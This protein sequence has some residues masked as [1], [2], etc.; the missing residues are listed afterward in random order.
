MTDSSGV[1]LELDGLSAFITGYNKATEA[2]AGF[3]RATESAAKGMN[4][5]NTAAQQLKIDRIAQQIENGNKTLAVYEQ[6]LDALRKKHGDGAQQVVIMENRIAAL[7][8]RLTLSQQALSLETDKL[9]ALEAG[10]DEAAGTTNRLTIELAQVDSAADQ[11]S[12][13]LEKISEIAI[14]AKRKL[15]ELAVEGVQRLGSD[16]LN[17][18]INVVTMAGDFEATMGRFSAVAGPLDDAGL[19]IEQFRDKFLELGKDTQFSAQQAGEA[20]I[21][22]AKGGVSITEVMGGATDA[23][24]ALA[25][26]AE[27]DLTQAATIVAKQLAVWGDEAGGAANIADQFSQAAAASTVNADDLALG[28]A[29]VGGVA[30]AAGLSFEETVATIGLISS[31]FSS[32]SDAGTSFKEFIARLQPDSKPA[33]EAMAELGLLTE[34]GTSAFYDAQGAFVGQ[35]EATR[36]LHEAT[37]DLS[38]AEQ[39]RL[40][41][42]AFGSDAQRTAI[43]L[44]KAGA[45]GYDK[46][47]EAMNRQGDAS[48]QAARKNVGFNFAL[49]QLRG[50]VE[51]AAIVW[52]DKL[53]PIG[54]KII[55]EFL[56]P[57]ANG[58]IT[59]A[60][61]FGVVIDFIK[62][63]AV[64]VIGGLVAILGSYALA[65]GGATLATY[66][67]GIALQVVIGQAGA[68]TA[69]FA[70]MAIP[71]AAI[72]IAVGGT[73]LAIQNYNEYVGSTI[74]ATLRLADGYQKGADALANYQTIAND[75]EGLSQ[76]TQFELIKEAA[77]V[78]GLRTQLE[79][80]TENYY[81]T[82]SNSEYWLSEIQRLNGELETHSTKL[83]TST[84]KNKELIE[85]NKQNE[86][87][88]RLSREGIVNFSAA[89]S[90]GVSGAEAMRAALIPTG[91]AAE[92]LN[93]A[94]EKI[95]ESGPAAFDAAVQGEVDYQ[96]QVESIT[97]DHEKKMKELRATGSA[98]QI[99]AQE[100]SYQIQMQNAAIAYAEQQAAQRA[101][102]GQML[103]DYAEAQGRLNGVSAEKIA[104]FTNGIADA[105]GVQQS[106]SDQTFGQMTDDIDA[107]A[108]SG[109]ANSAQVVSDLGA[110]GDAAVETQQKMD[111]LAKEYTAELIQNFEDGKIDADQLADALSKIPARVRSEV[112]IHTS[113][114]QSGAPPPGGIK[115]FQ[116]IEAR[117]EGGELNMVPTLVGEEGPELIFPRKPGWVANARL[118]RAII[119]APRTA[120]NEMSAETTRNMVIGG[121]SFRTGLR[122]LIREAVAEAKAGGYQIAAGMSSGL[123]AGIAPV[124]STLL[125]GLSGATRAPA[126]SMTP[127]WAARPAGASRTLLTGI[128]GAS[129]T[130]NV[131]NSLSQQFNGVMPPASY[132]P[133]SLKAISVLPN[134]G[135]GEFSV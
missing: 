48:D 25:S 14:G 84:D 132:G 45:E 129:V 32:A 47:T 8:G 17:L 16:L 61:N 30:R 125:G 97:A 77:I 123:A 104:E 72:G 13:G 127:D 51:T 113:Y 34:Q 119:N 50:S 122:N 81:S 107:W 38:E 86:E 56:I 91:E 69:A 7:T 85:A 49:E 36:L 95:R 71:L 80:A 4:Q 121:S 70:A 111:A 105:Y 35:T 116:P 93:D 99:A 135:A 20:A 92:K 124:S 10:A 54:T 89:A 42:A 57:A 74:E 90:Q 59:L 43:E 22:L 12:R 79:Q 73:I 133:A 130:N 5:F 76:K 37:K 52:G 75:M 106:L 115:P 62:T 98:D 40:L 1:K 128:S 28:L 134:L 9:R 53:L 3:T 109:G 100:E 31:G 55:N 26:A 44:A 27:V 78:A 120:V 29:N 101:H 118:T 23:T 65:A 114:T 108:A 58:A 21:E 2:Q 117:A 103:I 11:G 63:A 46:F 131:N 18:G 60:E 110:A 67:F 94:L 24:L 6:K 102:L 15:G 41:R 88:M 82:G 33:R 39:S 112:Q 19:T 64:P 68:A 66:P 96:A 83:Q 126:V 87:A